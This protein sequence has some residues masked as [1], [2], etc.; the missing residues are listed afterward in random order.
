METATGTT[1]LATA[2]ISKFERNRAIK[3]YGTATATV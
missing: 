2:T 1:I 3:K